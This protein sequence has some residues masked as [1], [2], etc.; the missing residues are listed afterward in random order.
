MGVVRMGKSRMGC[1]KLRAME[2]DVVRRLPL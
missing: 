1:A 2:I